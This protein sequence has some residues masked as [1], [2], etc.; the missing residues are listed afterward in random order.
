MGIAGCLLLIYLAAVVRV[1]SGEMLGIVDLSAVAMAVAVRRCF[2]GLAASLAFLAGLLADGLS[3]GPMGAQAAANVAAVAVLMRCG[4]APQPW[5]PG[6]WIAAVFCLIAANT[7]ATA[8]AQ[9]GPLFR[10]NGWQQLLISQSAAALATAALVGAIVLGG[11]M[12]YGASC[13]TR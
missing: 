4:Y 13:A 2:P 9:V 11:R 6:G 8:L 12:L 1:M 3:A 5:S 10:E 7:A